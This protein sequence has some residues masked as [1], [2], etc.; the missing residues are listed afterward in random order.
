[1]LLRSGG[2]QQLDRVVVED[3][4]LLGEIEAEPSQIVD[5]VSRCIDRVV[6]SEQHDG[7]LLGFSCLQNT[8][9][10]VGWISLSVQGWW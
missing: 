4:A 2:S 7:D 6:R 5:G 9:H 10:M 1:M 8:I 3:L